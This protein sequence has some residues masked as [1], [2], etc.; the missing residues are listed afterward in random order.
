MTGLP[1]SYC[2]H[3]GAPV[4]TEQ[5]ETVDVA[6]TGRGPLC[7]VCRDLEPESAAGPRRIGAYEIRGVLGKGAVGVVYDAFD[8]RSGQRVALKTL[9]DEAG[10]A[11]I[12]RQR[13][14]RESAILTRL[15]HPGIVSAIDVGE[16]DG[17]AWIA[18]PRLEGEDLEALVYRDGA[19]P[20]PRAVRWGFKI[21]QALHHAHRRKVV[22]R[23]VK[24]SNLLLDREGRVRILD[25]GLAAALDASGIRLTAT[26]ATLGT[27]HF[28]PPEQI[29]GARRVDGRADVYS[30]GATIFF[31]V[32]GEI[33]WS[34]ARRLTE[35]FRKIQEAP[36][37]AIGDAGPPALDEVL[38]R[39]MAKSPDDR[40]ETAREFGNALADLEAGR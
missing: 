22:H 39:A 20:W 7:L 15:D 17:V 12:Q 13:F 21:S 28:M 11:A 5:L 30:L 10:L 1:A 26:H 18:M 34:G 38:R 2:R 9:S 29:G 3:C 32:T 24:P 19:V 37:P 25:F 6:Q 36:P 35:I 8:T 23:D 16:D 31:L 14:V 27:P 33:P 4:D 40:F